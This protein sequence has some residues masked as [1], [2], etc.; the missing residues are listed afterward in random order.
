MRRY[1]IGDTVTLGGASED[2]AVTN[3][4]RLDIVRPDGSHIEK[5]WDRRMPT[6]Q[7]DRTGVWSWTMF[8]RAGESTRSEWGE[9]EVVA[10]VH[11]PP[12]GPVR[13]LLRRV[14][15]RR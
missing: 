8:V 15:Y 9:F 10:G 13:R 5:D 2:R 1:H 12:I 14:R 7:V 11:V 4:N 6:I 3:V